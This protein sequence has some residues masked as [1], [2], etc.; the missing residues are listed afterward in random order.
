MDQKAANDICFDQPH[1][2]VIAQGFATERWFNDGQAIGTGGILCPKR[3]SLKI[4]HRYYR[5]TSSTSAR[6]A[7]LGG[8]WWI[9]FDDFNTIRHYAERHGLEFTY[10]ARLFLALPYEWS[11]VDRIISAL[12]KEPVDAYAGEGKVAKMDKDKWT[13]IQHMKVTQLYIPGLVSNSDGNDLYNR[14][15]EGVQSK[16]AHN[17]K[18]L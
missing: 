8:G 17:Q 5:L 14:I 12:L 13:P 18:P 2:R 7:Q 9:S 16:Y 3:M 1:W 6:A 10:A 4:H 11:R 15:W